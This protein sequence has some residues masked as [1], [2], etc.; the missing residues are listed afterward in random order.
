MSD[1]E[2]L[3]CADCGSA[4]HP[5]EIFPNDRCINCHAKAPEIINEA[6]IMTANKLA[7]MWKGDR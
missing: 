4:V 5:L 7:D 6:A 2:Q 1:D 3:E